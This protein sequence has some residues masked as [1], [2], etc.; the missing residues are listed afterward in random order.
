MNL[1]LFATMFTLLGMKLL[2]GGHC[3]CVSTILLL[4]AVSVTSSLMI[5]SLFVP[6]TNLSIDVYDEA[7]SAI[8]EASVQ[9]HERAQT[10]FEDLRAAFF[11]E[12]Q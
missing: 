8:A 12:Q 2:F 1:P 4:A 7:F 6:Q 11:A 5:E 9:M 3:V 10:A